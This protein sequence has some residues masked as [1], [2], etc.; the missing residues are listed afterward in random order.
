M[1]AIYRFFIFWY[2]CGVILLTFDLIPPWLEWANSVF[3]ITAGLVSALY[4]ISMYGA[5][6]GVSYSIWIIVGSIF[7]EHLGVEYN[8]LFG[9]YDYTNNF[10]FKLFDTPITIGFAWLLIIGCSH[11]ISRVISK[12]NQSLLSAS[13]FVILGSLLAVTMDLILDPVSFKIKE[14]W[15]W[16]EPGFYY[17]IPLSNFIGWFVVAAVFHITFVIIS[18]QKQPSSSIWEKRMALVFGLIIGMFCLI[19]LIGKLYFAVL[20]VTTLTVTWYVLY[21]ARRSSNDSSEKE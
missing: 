21:F 12:G 13:C 6:F 10:G 17:D 5:R 7:V 1:T 19:A 11:E 15:I 2:I 18:P 4:F 20:L 8:F 3:L 14:Y 16:L 9:S